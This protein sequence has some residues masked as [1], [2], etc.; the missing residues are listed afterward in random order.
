[1]R[2]DYV[3]MSGIIINVPDHQNRSNVSSE[4]R[5]A[6]AVLTP[7]NNR[8]KEQKKKVSGGDKK[9]NRPTVHQQKCSSKV[10]E[11]THTQSPWLFMK[12]PSI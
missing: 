4:S 12:K 3:C 8:T 7:T 1:M 5:L 10:G 6:T 2:H 11:E 9:K